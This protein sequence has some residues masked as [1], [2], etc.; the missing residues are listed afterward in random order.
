ML[1]KFTNS[2][3]IERERKKK[4]ERGRRR[5]RR[6]REKEGVIRYW[7][8]LVMP[9]GWMGD[10]ERNQDLQKHRRGELLHDPRK[11]GDMDAGRT[12]T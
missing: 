8:T 4:G 10:P 11:S 1:I 2:S 7:K 5:E 3:E 6:K 12:R 9:P